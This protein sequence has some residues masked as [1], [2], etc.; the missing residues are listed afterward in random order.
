MFGTIC[1]RTQTV[2]EEMSPYITQVLD[3]I[4]GRRTKN[5]SQ[6][7]SRKGRRI[8][9]TLSNVDDIFWIS[10]VRVQSGTVPESCAITTGKTR[11]TTRTVPRKIIILK[12]VFGA[13]V[14]SLSEI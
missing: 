12:W 6:K 5:L 9:G 13:K 2:P 1:R 4:D 3:G 14:P 11:S 7:F 10:K 8:L